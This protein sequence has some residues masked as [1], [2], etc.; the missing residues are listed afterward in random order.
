MANEQVVSSKPNYRI[1]I[2]GDDEN[3]KERL[4][5]AIRKSLENSGRI[6]RTNPME[7]TFDGYLF[8]STI[9]PCDAQYEKNLK[10]G[11]IKLDGIILYVDALKGLDLQVCEQIKKSYEYGI[12][13]MHVCV[14]NCEEKNGEIKINS[15]VE[16]DIRNFI[17]TT[18]FNPCNSSKALAGN[19]LCQTRICDLV[20]SC[21]VLFSRSYENPDEFHVDYKI[22]KALGNISAKSPLTLFPIRLETSFCK[23]DSKKQLRV[24]IIPDEIMLDYKANSKLTEDEIKNGK[25]FWI[26]WYIAS[27]CERREYEAWENLC[28]KYPLYKAARICRE[29]RPVDFGKDTFKHR[30][31]YVNSANKGFVGNVVSSEE[32]ADGSSIEFIESKCQTI[33]GLLSEIIF[34]E[35]KYLI[36]KGKDEETSFEN[37]VRKNLSLINGFVF[38][39]ESLLLSC[40]KIVD[41]L[42]DNVH[43]TFL[44]LQRRLQALYSIYR[45]LSC[46]STPRSL[47]IWDIDFSIL[48]SLLEKTELFLKSLDNRRI[49]L[50]DMVELYL[51]EKDK[52]KFPDV[53]S[54]KSDDFIVPVCKCLPNQFVFVGEAVTKNKEKKVIIEL[55]KKVDASKIQMSFTK[56]TTDGV[57]DPNEGLDD[58]GELSLPD[59][60]NMKWMTDYDT[61]EKYGMAITVNIDSNV[62]EFNYI[63]VFGVNSSSSDD[64]RKSVISD[65]IYGH[66]YV[67]S[68]VRFVNA[69]TPTNQ[70]DKQFEDEDDFL[71]RVRYE[72]EVKEIYKDK[73]EYPNEDGYCDAMK[74][75]YLLNGSTDGFLNTWARIVGF[76]S[77]QDYYAEIAYGALWDKYLGNVFKGNF[78]REFFVKH[79]RARGNFATF[80]VDNLPYGILPTSDFVQMCEYLQK[81]NGNNDLKY[82]LY[83]L[84]ELADK[85]NACRNKNVKC[86]ENIDGADAQQKYLEMAGQTP[87]S[88][89]YYTR[90]LLDSSLNPSFI[91]SD[92]NENIKDLSIIGYF[93]KEENLRAAPIADVAVLSK[94][95]NGMIKYLSDTLKSKGLSISQQDVSLYVSEFLDLLTHRLDAWFMGILDYCFSKKIKVV[96]SPYVGAFGWVFNLQDKHRTEVSGNEKTNLLKKME[97]Q[98][99]GKIYESSQDGHFILAPSIQHALTASVLRGSYIKSNAQ[100]R[101]DSQ[102]CVNL[103]SARVRQALRLVDGVRS[104]MSLSVILGSDF[105]RYLHEAHNIYKRKVKDEKGNVVKDEWGKDVE[106][107]VEMDEFIY[108]LRQCFPQCVQ[109]EAGDKHANDYVMQ[110]VNGEAL[111]NSFIKD[112]AWSKPVSEWLQT[113]WDDRNNGEEPCI[114]IETLKVCVECNDNACRLDESKFDVLFKI[115]ERLMDSYDALNDLLLSEGVHRLIMGDRASYNAISKFLAGD[116]DGNLPEPDILNI[117]SEHVVVSHKAGVLLPQRLN[118]IPNKVMCN[119]EPALNEWIEQQL[120]GMENI[121]FFIQKTEK[122]KSKTLTCSLADLDISG[123]EYVYLSAFDKTFRSYLEARVYTSSKKTFTDFIKSSSD[124]NSFFESAAEAGCKCPD[125][126]IS[127][128]DNK[129][130]LESIRGLIAR[131]RSMSSSDWCHNLCEDKPDDSLIDLDDLKMRLSNAISQ[132][133][134]IKG[135]VKKWLDDAPVEIILED[136]QVKEAY[137]LLCDCYESG[138]IN[139]LVQYDK[140]AFIGK[141]TQASNAVEYNQVD[142]IQQN[143]RE[144]MQKVYKNL[145]ERID[146]AQKRIGE[147]SCAD[148]FVSALQSVTLSNF[149]ICYKFNTALG[150]NATAISPMPLTSYTNIGNETVFDKW[151]D[152]VSEVREGMKIMQ[153]FSMTQLALDRDLE[154]VSILQTTISDD[155]THVDTTFEKWLGAEVENESDLRDADSLILYNSSEYSK[156]SKYYSGFVF[157]S[158]IEYIPYKKHDAGLAFHSDWPNAEAPQGILVAW[159]PSL[160]VVPNDE[161]TYCDSWD[162][163]TLLNVV[164]STHEMMMNRAVEPDYI[165]QD[166]LLSKLLPLTPKTGKIVLPCLDEGIFNI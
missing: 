117:P 137:S 150:E 122:G 69:G 77:A 73:K 90:T 34:D 166:P 43:E 116:I 161:K 66:N 102:I 147:A 129:L 74:I 151:Q 107:G 55:S 42:Y 82:L 8:A 16:R 124:K 112:W 92:A 50:A 18:K 45:K 142:L 76:D 22:N 121:L 24:R 63:Y 36:E 94:V 3:G 100:K 118:K 56:P 158:W 119:A 81:Q 128:E 1:G 159:H 162:V 72:I 131:A 114:F 139:C 4:V 21:A 113:A 65:L 41:Y 93:L 108:P 59:N 35:S 132:L 62:D 144:E 44:Y 141:I 138:L 146:E 61:A 154:P 57:S 78:I 103:S 155:G 85:W 46:L 153:Q 87:Y 134:I 23:Q 10:N 71:K 33:Y 110:V 19:E 30:R 15:K 127:L 135:N 106:D 49:A 120:G 14:D 95:D 160:P 96:K 9:I 38:E 67:N 25:F 39:I 80:R 64:V 123:V 125:A 88:V 5:K 12:T 17:S 105:E 99:D 7:F 6:P 13:R 28:S 164:R 115:I 52:F 86:S 70:I 163:K 98:E 83:S 40:D 145:A 148:D 111:L 26:Q 51:Q 89:S 29:L 149:K 109:L 133:G 104:G 31:P 165:Y 97:I 54:T 79:V 152:E 48:K 157:D 140:T 75:A 126:K 130:R 58:N 156:Y 47:E 91:D 27:G 2:F 53:E 11:N 37:V 20:T 68:N 84:I 32:I 136:S 101:S 143:L 60:P